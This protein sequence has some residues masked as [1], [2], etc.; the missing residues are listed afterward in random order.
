[1][2]F[3]PVRPESPLRTA[4]DEPAGGVDVDLGL[5]VQQ[6][7]RDDGLD[8]QLDHILPDLVQGRL[9]P[10]LGGDHHRVHPQGRFS[11]SYSTVTWVLPSGRR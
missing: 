4:D 5:I 6:L 2:I 7:G 10:V 9:R 3:R 11:P 8:D 1:M